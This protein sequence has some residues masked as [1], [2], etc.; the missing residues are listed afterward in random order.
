MDHGIHGQPCAQC[1]EHHEG[2]DSLHED[3][4]SANLSRAVYYLRLARQE[5]VAEGL[6]MR[7]LTKSVKNN[8]NA[9][10]YLKHCSTRTQMFDSFLK[11][12]QYV[13]HTT[14]G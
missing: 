3:N 10:D 5:G 14:R 4:F 12:S 7:V 9:P 13:L 8:L 1:E 6:E 11:S 2:K